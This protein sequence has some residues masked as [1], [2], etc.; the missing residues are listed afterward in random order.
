MSDRRFARLTRRAC[1][2]FALLLLCSCRMA[3]DNSHVQIVQ[4]ADHGKPVLAAAAPKIDRNVVP[5]S[6]FSSLPPDAYTGSPSDGYTV[7]GVVPPFMREAASNGG[8]VTI[9]DNDDRKGGMSD[10]T[11]LQ[12]TRR[13]AVAMTPASAPM[14]MN[15]FGPWRPPGIGGSWPEDEYIFDGDDQD[16]EVKVR[17]DFQLEG[18]DSEDTIVHYDT[19]AGRTAVCPSNRVCIYAPRFAAVRQ[20]ILPYSEAQLVRAGGVDMP[21]GPVGQDRIQP[22]TT[23]IQPISPV[24]EIGQRAPVTFIDRMPPVGL[25]AN[26]VIRATVDRLKPYEN[27]ELVKT[28]RLE[29]NEKPFLAIAVES[30]VVWTLDQGVQVEIDH[31]KAV[32]LEGDRKVQATYK[33]DEPNYPCVRICKLASAASARPGD[34]IEFTLRFDNAGNQPVGNVTIVD[35]L[36]TRLELV[37][38]SGQCSRKAKFMT[39]PNK[40]GSLVLRWEIDEPLNPGQGGIARFKCVVR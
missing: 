3:N 34:I 31:K 5:A 36:T 21:I 35:N 1:S 16:G 7:P 24:G 27:F 40:D 23:A 11:V 38:D 29:E 39:E 15:N 18:L 26:T 12:N 2:V 17:D 20:V 28:G 6:G 32:V 9:N 4:M 30:A 14:P 33:V 19:L 8:V 22:V 13:T 10:A 25:I 37:P